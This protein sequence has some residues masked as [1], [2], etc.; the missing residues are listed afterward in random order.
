[1]KNKVRLIL[2]IRALDIGGAERQFLEL[3][4]KIDHTKFEVLVITTHKGALDQEIEGYPYFNANKT[5]RWDFGALLRLRKKILEFEPRVI[6]TFM[7]DMNITLALMKFTGLGKFK[8]IWGQ[9]GSEPDFA[10]YGKIRKRV[11]MVQQKL[12]FMSDALISDGSRG[13]EFLKKFHHKLE[14]STV[15]VSGTD[16]QRF[17]RNSGF[18]SEFRAKYNLSDTDI[19]IGICSRLDPMKGYHVLAKAAK[20]ILEKYPNVSFYSIGYGQDSIMDDA[21]EYFGDYSSRFIWFG[22]QSKP[23][24]IMSGWDIYCSSSLYGEGFSNAIIEAMACSL[25]VIATDV[26]DAP[27]QVEGV[28]LIL[29]PGDDE[30]LF[31]SLDTW[32]GQGAYKETGIA[33]KERVKKYFSSTLMAKR[34]EDYILQIVDGANESR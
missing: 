15:I 34:T 17:D 28:G 4:K 16:I 23:E 11:Y 33:S 6:Y 32:I 10:A 3:V 9:F 24:A 18:R 29:E 25:P 22:K 12:E 26:G 20:R 31:K 8:L 2:A 27:H 19:A 13:I 14:P 1:M 7:P 30:A 5:G 21:K